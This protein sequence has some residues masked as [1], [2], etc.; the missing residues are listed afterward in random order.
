M[1]K[2]IT[3][4][5]ITCGLSSPVWASENAFLNDAFFTDSQLTLSAKNYWKYLKE[6]NANP[7][8]VHNAWGQGFAADYQSGYFA[9]IIGFD[10]TYYSAIKLN[11]C[12]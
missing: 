9:D 12:A 2:Y 4:T 11:S 7:K 1:L 8:H 10:I 3:L 5:L 6:E